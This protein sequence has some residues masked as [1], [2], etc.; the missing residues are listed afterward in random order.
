MATISPTSGSS[1]AGSEP[2][3][4]EFSFERAIE[5]V[6]TLVQRIERGEIGLEASLAAYQRGVTLLKKCRA[7]LDQT[8]Q[9]ITE[10]SSALENPPS[11][12]GGA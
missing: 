1:G 3:G 5:E 7:V 11:S 6:E 4:D 12:A 9:R 2:R 10:L 8:E